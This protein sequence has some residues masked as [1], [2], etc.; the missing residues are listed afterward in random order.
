MDLT[1]VAT[2]DCS[3]P[4]E[5]ATIDFDIGGVRYLGCPHAGLL[6]NLQQAIVLRWAWEVAGPEE[7]RE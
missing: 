7:V 5:A 2:R 4:P 6:V 3:C 1:A